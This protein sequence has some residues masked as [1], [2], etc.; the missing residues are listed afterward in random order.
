LIAGSDQLCDI[1]SIFVFVSF[2]SIASHTLVHKGCSD[3]W[4]TNYP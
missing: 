4:E 3:K 1:L 2:F